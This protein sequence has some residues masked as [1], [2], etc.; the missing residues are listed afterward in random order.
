MLAENTLDRRFYELL[1]KKKE[2]AER[3]QNLSDEEKSAASASAGNAN[4]QIAK[5]RERKWAALVQMEQI[6]EQYRASGA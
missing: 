5:I 6:D 1:K 2:I 3:I 4:E